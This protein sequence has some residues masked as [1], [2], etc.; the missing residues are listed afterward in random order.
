MSLST[1]NKF[2]STSSGL[3][4]LI[5]SPQHFKAEKKINFSE[6]IM[7]GIVVL[8]AFGFPFILSFRQKT[9]ETS[10]S[11]LIFILILPIV[12]F[13]FYY[14][15]QYQRH[16]IIEI[17]SDN[18]TVIEK[19]FSGKIAN[20]SCVSLDVNMVSEVKKIVHEEIRKR[21]THEKRD[22][23]TYVVRYRTIDTKDP[24]YKFYDIISGLDEGQANFLSNKIN[25]MILSKRNQVNS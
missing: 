8:F 5:D 25:E 1:N 10:I 7:M 14:N 4:I 22:V 6:A 12:F 21:Y 23:I 18:I 2:N 17:T 13:L 11:P 9:P 19:N 16:S 24:N 3:D 20:N 15:I